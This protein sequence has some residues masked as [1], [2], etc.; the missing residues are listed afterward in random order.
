MFSGWINVSNYRLIINQPVINWFRDRVGF[1]DRYGGLPAYEEW[2]NDT[3][4]LLRSGN[5][6]PLELNLDRLPLELG[7]NQPHFLIIIYPS[8][9]ESQARARLAEVWREIIHLPYIPYN[10]KKRREQ[11]ADAYDRLASYIDVWEKTKNKKS[12]S[13]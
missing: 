11:L 3:W 4:K 9:E 12:E 1:F 7:T 2:T 5:C 13:N 8:Q 6:P 10:I